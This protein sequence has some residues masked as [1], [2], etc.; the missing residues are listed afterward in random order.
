MNGK[1]RRF[2]QTSVI[3]KW[4]V[5]MQF[6]MK[7]TTSTTISWTLSI[8]SERLQRTNF[9]CL[10]AIY[11]WTN[12]RSCYGLRPW[13]SISQL[14]YVQHWGYFET[15]IQDAHILQEICGWHTDYHARHNISSQFPRDFKPVP[16]RFLVIARFPF[17]APSCSTNTHMLRLR[18][19]LN[20]Q[21]L[22]FCCITRAI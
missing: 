8:F 11:K 3:F 10:T 7:H 4:I 6:R 2:D 22:T 19:T 17:W 5:R 18:C 21:I 16:F 9:Y 13:S 20:P 15:W 14:F 12:R 1:T